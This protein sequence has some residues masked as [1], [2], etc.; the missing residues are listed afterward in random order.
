LLHITIEQRLQTLVEVAGRVS[1]SFVGFNG[2]QDT[3][4]LTE[5]N[6]DPYFPPE[7]GHLLLFLNG[8]LQPPGSSYTIFGDTVQFSEPPT[9]GSL[10]SA[11]YL[12]KLRQLDDIGFQFDSLRSTFNLKLNDSFYSL[13]LTDGV[14]SSTI[15][16]ENNII[17]SLNGVIQEPGV[18][19]ELVGSRV[20][21]AEVPRAGSTFVAFSYIGSDTDVI[22]VDVIPPVEI[23]R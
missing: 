14:Q 1:R 9:I 8:V 11:V 21:F 3:F 23:W 16:P 22:S 2:I 5:N 17:I 6:G 12:G 10:F 20:I 13:T 18:A 19:F 7:D 15:R 4:A